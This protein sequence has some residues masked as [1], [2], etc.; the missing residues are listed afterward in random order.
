M[1]GATAGAPR[2]LAQRVPLFMQKSPNAAILTWG[3]KE[4]G[5]RGSR[6]VLALEASLTFDKL[7]KNQPKASKL[8]LFE[9]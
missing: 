9:V 3:G 4:E 6:P 2:S 5:V 1:F 8:S 7:R